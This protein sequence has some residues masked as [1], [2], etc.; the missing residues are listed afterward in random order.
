MG[1]LAPVQTDLEKHAHVVARRPGRHRARPT[2]HRRTIG[3]GAARD[4][5]AECHEVADVTA[6]VLRVALAIAVELEADRE[7][8]TRTVVH[9]ALAPR[10]VFDADAGLTP[11]VDADATA[12]VVV[13]AARERVAH[14]AADARAATVALARLV[15]PIAH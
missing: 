14:R 11:E 1:S 15:G 2:A 6:S 3:L 4:E 9:A 12:L 13:G 7:L 5:A 8:R 10:H